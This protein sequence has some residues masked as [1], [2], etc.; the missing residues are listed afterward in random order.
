MSIRMQIYLTEELYEQ[1]K[2]KSRQSGQP[3]AEHIRESLG[4]YL[5][6]PDTE[7]LTTADPIWNISG[8]VKSKDGDLSVNHDHYLY[9]TENGDQS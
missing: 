4:K 8:T 6:E 3:M 5:A 2:Q 1:L 7:G 9:E